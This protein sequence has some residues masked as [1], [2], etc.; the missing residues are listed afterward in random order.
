MDKVCFDH[1]SGHVQVKITIEE[2]CLKWLHSNK[3]KEATNLVYTKEMF[4]LVVR[5]I[6]TKCYERFF[7]YLS[8]FLY[9]ISDS[10]HI[11]DLGF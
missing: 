6:I 10:I 3:G 5:L 8:T 9:Q 7:R 4:N 1:M 11:F 2:E